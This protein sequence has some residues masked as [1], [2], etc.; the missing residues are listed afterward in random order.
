MALMPPI[1]MAG[2]LVPPTPP[3]LPA[4]FTT[5]TQAL[6]AGLPFTFALDR[7]WSVTVRYPTGVLQPWLDADPRAVASSDADERVPVQANAGPSTADPVRLT[8]ARDD[9]AL[10]VVPL[11]ASRRALIVD[12]GSRGVALELAVLSWTIAAGTVCG[13]GSFGSSLTLAWRPASVAVDVFAPPPLSPVVA[14][15]LPTT[16]QPPIG[17]PLLISRTAILRDG[18]LE[19][20]GTQPERRTVRWL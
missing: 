9:V 18:V 14:L 19:A 6:D 12:D 3:D 7:H 8:V 4:N 1:P 17:I 20:A 2:F 15:R 5:A 10:A 11:D 13:A 16:V